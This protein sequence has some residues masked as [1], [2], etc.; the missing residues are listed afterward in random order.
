MSIENRVQAILIADGNVTA[1]C[2]ASRIRVPGDWQNLTRPYVVHFPVSTEPQRNHSGLED[3]CIW[4]PYQISVF[5][6]SYS[7]ARA[8]ADVIRTALDGTHATGV[9]AHWQRMFRSPDDP[10]LAIEHIVSEYRISESLT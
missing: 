8:L 9:T 3:L 4:D 5:G 2:P 7:T 10:N 1:L 6:D